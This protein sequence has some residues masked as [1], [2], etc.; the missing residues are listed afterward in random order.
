MKNPWIK[1]SDDLPSID[2]SNLK[3]TPETLLDV[4][5][6]IY[7]HELNEPYPIE[8]YIFFLTV[9]E[10]V[11]YANIRFVYPTIYYLIHST[12]M[13]IIKN[14]DNVELLIYLIDNYNTNID[15]LLYYMINNN[16][17]NFVN[18]LSSL[19]SINIHKDDED[20]VSLASLHGY[21]D[22]LKLLVNKGSGKN[23][24]FEKSMIYAADIGYIEI[25]KFLFSLSPCIEVRDNEAICKASESGH[26]EIVK[27]L[28]DKGVDFHTNDDYPFNIA[29]E[30]GYFEVVKILINKCKDIDEIR[31]MIN[32][33]GQY[34]IKLAYE[35]G[36]NEMVDYL[37]SL[38]NQK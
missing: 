31:N 11:N 3:V 10:E 37:T 30:N 8:F 12:P 7:S 20:L 21:I 2:M 27:F 34:A 28:I 38:L 5:C 32:T 19:P 33:K 9:K 13:N 23:T 1:N 4:C 35:N 22:I 18:Y 6:F 24:K 14:S 25:V 26:D 16:N 17:I 15:K 36:Y 29:C